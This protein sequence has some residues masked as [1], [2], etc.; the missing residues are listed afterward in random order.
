MNPYFGWAL[1]AVMIAVAW[2]SYGWQGV[3][4]AVTVIVFW[5][6][7]QFNRALRAMKNA[8][9]APVGRVDS[10]VMLNAKLEAGM[11]MLKV[12]A[13][14]RSLGRKVAAEP[15]TWAWADDGGSEVTVELQ[16]GKVKR[17]QLNR[18]N[19]PANP[20]TAP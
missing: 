5:L 3:L 15:E 17:W 10:A 18:P 9:A 11:P 1:A 19:D 12:I 4:F 14:T 16:G 8:A 20:V 13:L 7:L 2:Q 6:L